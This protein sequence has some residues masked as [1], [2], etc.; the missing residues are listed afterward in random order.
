MYRGLEPGKV[1]QETRSLAVRLGIYLD[2]ELGEQIEQ[3]VEESVLEDVNVDH[4][5]KENR[6]EHSWKSSELEEDIN[7]ES[8]DA[9][10]D[11]EASKVETKITSSIHNSPS[12]AKGMLISQPLLHSE[13]D[14]PVSKNTMMCIHC[15][16][17]LKTKESLRIH[18][19]NFHE[20][21]AFSCSECDLSFSCE[22][23]LRIHKRTS[24]DHSIT[25][26]SFPCPICGKQLKNNFTFKEHIL[27]H[28]EPSVQCEICN[29]KFSSARTLYNHNKRTHDE[30]KF[31][32]EFC[33]KRFVGRNFLTNHVAAVHTLERRFQCDN[34]EYKAKT[35]QQLREHKLRHSEPRYECKHCG[36]KMVSRS[37]WLTHEMTHTG[38]KPYAC[39]ECNYRCIQCNDMKKHYLNKHGMKIRNPLGVQHNRVEVSAQKGQNQV[40]RRSSLEFIEFSEVEEPHNAE[41]FEFNVKT[42]TENILK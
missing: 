35:R 34:C 5:S 32:C 30:K 24:I 13:E 1:S 12:E 18:I 9:S 23:Q 29:L 20:G 33:P 15:G 4:L 19:K 38:E 37:N 22:K 27:R 25:G 36:K 7:I 10:K 2:N 3:V 14:E 21:G 39:T 26:P 42:E 40:L 41:Y 31:V 17:C 28:N 11:G 6:N 8:N 16:K